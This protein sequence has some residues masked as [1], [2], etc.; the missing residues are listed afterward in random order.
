MS[1]PTKRSAVDA[2]ASRAD[3][4][5][6]QH[7]VLILS[8]DIVAAALLGGL[9]ETLGYHVR[10][11]Q[12]PEDPEQALK[13]ERPSVAMVD[14]ADTTLMREDLLGRA[15]MRNISV[16]IFGSPDALR[17]V[18][19]LAVDHALDTLIMPASLES[20]DETLRKAVA[21]TC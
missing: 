21:D 5:P 20:L 15:R 10:F 18:R 14:C 7:V 16:V 12:P 11:Y 8:P 1:A 9:V 17:N 3:Y 4:R 19:K 2:P 13:R 6:G